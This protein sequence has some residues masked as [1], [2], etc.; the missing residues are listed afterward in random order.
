MFQRCYAC[1][2]VDPGE[3]GLQGPNLAGVVGQRAGMRP[4][5]D[6]SPAMRRAG[7]RGLVWTEAALDRFLAD[8]EAVVPKT[9]MFIPPLRRPAERAAVIAYLKNPKGR[10]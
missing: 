5:F 6:Y 7:A 1:H 8:P 2:S 10:R 4:G 3:T 9:E